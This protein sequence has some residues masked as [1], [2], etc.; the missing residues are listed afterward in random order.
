MLFMRFATNT[1]NNDNDSKTTKIIS[2]AA[3]VVDCNRAGLQISKCL[4]QR[5]KVK[6]EK[7]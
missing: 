3:S 2:N 5:R 4:R 6:R 7:G 1:G